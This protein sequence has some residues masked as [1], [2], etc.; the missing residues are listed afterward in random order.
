MKLLRKASFNNVSFEVSAG[1]VSVGRRIVTHEFPQRDTPYS[2]DLGRAYRQFT[3][4]GF[5]TGADYIE[6]ARR[7]QEA[8]ES[9]SKGRLIHPWLG[10]LDVIVADKTTITWDTASRLASFDITFIEL[11]EQK[12]P[13]LSRSFISKLKSI[14]DDISDECYNY[15]VEAMESIDYYAIVDA[16]INDSWFDISNKL[17]N[18]DLVR[19][20]GLEDL[21]D[22]T[23]TVAAETLGANAGNF[24][25]LLQNLLS[26]SDNTADTRNF[27]QTILS[28][29]TLAESKPF[30][31]Q[32]LN[33]TQGQANNCIRQLCRQTLIADVIGLCTA[34]GASNDISA[35]DD[36]KVKSYDEIVEVQNRVLELLESEMIATEDDGGEVYQSLEKA[37]SSV[38]QHLSINICQSKQLY[39]DSVKLVCP[40]LNLAYDRYEDAER[41]DEIT[42]RNRI[43]NPLFVSGDI[44]V[45]NS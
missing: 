9:D 34:V 39:T 37:Y 38:Y 26:L 36:A 21:L 14:A 20:F 5:V 25:K 8:L 29:C 15:F 27:R 41:A 22:Y 28:L 6:K 33:S 17:K 7:L 44:K 45:L 31:N 30:Q 11:G 18:S 2:E 32:G 42:S 19:N 12:D 13:S 4:S 35:D 10:T 23:D 1:S 24:A 3:V 16:V 40:A 43:V